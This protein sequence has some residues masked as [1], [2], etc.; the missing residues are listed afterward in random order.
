[1]LEL[2]VC[3]DHCGDDLLVEYR[4]FKVGNIDDGE[5]SGGIGRRCFD[6][7]FN[8]LGDVGS[9]SNSPSAGLDD[10]DLLGGD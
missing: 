2:A 9:D 6:Q 7:V 1:M 8:D 3:W 4:K 10:C 5:L